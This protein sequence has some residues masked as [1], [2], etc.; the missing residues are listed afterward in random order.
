M[1]GR[2][3][4]ISIHY[5]YQIVRQHEVLPDNKGVFEVGPMGFAKFSVSADKNRLRRVFRRA[6]ELIHRIYGRV[7]ALFFFASR[8]SA[9][10]D[11][12]M[13]TYVYASE[14]IGS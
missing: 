4:S 11:C 3:Y 14:I 13:W 1:S 6:V 10:R 12:W 7:R 2:I 8:R 9:P 5:T